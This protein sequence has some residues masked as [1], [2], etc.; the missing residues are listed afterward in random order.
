MHA[1]CNVTQELNGAMNSTCLTYL[2]PH[3]AVDV[4]DLHCLKHIIKTE[5]TCV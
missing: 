1:W 4:L 5:V 2:L 3:K